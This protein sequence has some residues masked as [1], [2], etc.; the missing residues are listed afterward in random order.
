MSLLA[1]FAAHEART[2]LR[3]LR[4]RLLA[5]LYLLVST[6]PAVFVFGETRFGESLF[7]AATYAAEVLV[8]LPLATALLASSLALDGIQR[9]RQDGTWIVLTRAGLSNAGYLLRRWAA[10]LALLLPLSAL[11]LAAAALLATAAGAP[12]ASLGPFLY[13]WLLRVVPIAVAASGAALGVGTIVDSGIVAL[14]TLYLLVLFLPAAINDLLARSGRVATPAL[15]WLGTRDVALRWSYFKAAR[16][17]GMTELRAFL[18]ATEGGYDP[19]AGAEILGS[20]AALPLGLALALLGFSARF[21]RR[22]RPDLP[23]WRVRPDHPLRSYLNAANRLRQR[24]AP[25]PVPARADRAL[26]MAGLLA[27]AAGGA[28]YALREGHYAAL[29]RERYAAETKGWPEPTPATVVP[30]PWRLRAEIAGDG[31]L[32]STVDATLRNDGAGPVERVAFSLN[33]GVALATLEAGEGSASV[34]RSWDRL[35]VRLDPPLPPGASRRL[36]F[37]LAGTPERVSFNLQGFYRA[38]FAARFGRFQTLRFAADLSDLSSSWTVRGASPRRVA[39]QADD[40]TPVPRYTTWE[41]TRPGADEESIGQEVPAER[42]FPAA[43]LDYSISAPAGTY[44]AES[45]GR[46]TVLGGRPAAA[47]LAGRCRWPLGTWRVLGGALTEERIS[48]LRFAVLPGH[49]ERARFHAPALAGMRRQAAEAWPGLAL[50][51][52]IVLESSPPFGPD[53]F[54]DMGTW[55]VYAYDQGTEARASGALLVLPERFL[56]GGKKI[57]SSR[58]AAEQVTEALLA[59]R[60]I[61]FAE[62]SIFRALLET[63]ALRR[64][65][66]GAASGATLPGRYFEIEALLAPILPFDRW[67]DSRSQ[68]RLAAAVAYLDLLLG[69]ANVQ[70]GV[71]TF[72]SRRGGAPGTLRELLGDLGATGGV[73]LDALYREVFAGDALPQLGLEGVGVERAAQGDRFVVSGRLANSGTGEADCPVSVSTESGPL[74]TRVRVAPHGSTPFAIATRLPPRAVQIDPNRECFR[75]APVNNGP[76]VQQVDLTAKVN[77]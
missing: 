36:R 42:V 49:V 30:G 67:H 26:W 72:L 45:C 73:S 41:L 43:D 71:E 39:L 57:S 32:R 17:S 51:E 66:L 37:R 20:P 63:L 59:R 16:R 64:L 24:Y 33:R 47:P 14:I 76:L 4:F 8:V 6:L 9:E 46:T 10:L 38:P 11:P 22:C 55:Y 13:P 75:F 44:L 61:D 56:V 3:S 5:S 48:G 69:P 70:R 7:G 19:R 34:R 52:P 25:D 68:A 29:A 1:A 77:R 40:L 35:E 2:Q 27:L 31:S 60:E 15:A 28:V 53:P 54:A 65:G 12:P 74:E 50:P 21:L 18:P 62:Q 58:L 23:P